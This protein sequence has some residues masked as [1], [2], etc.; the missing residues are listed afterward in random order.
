LDALTDAAAAPA[1]CLG[2]LQCWWWWWCTWHNADRCW[3]IHATKPC[4]GQLYIQLQHLLL[5]CARHKVTTHS[6]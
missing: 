4:G 1:C 5:F 2:F 3:S 6:R